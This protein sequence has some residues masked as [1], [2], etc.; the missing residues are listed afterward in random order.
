M[1]LYSRDYHRKEK[2][3][4]SESELFGQMLAVFGNQV[5]PFIEKCVIVLFPL[6]QV[7][8]AYGVSQIDVHKLKESA[9]LESSQLLACVRELMPAVVVAKVA[10][11]LDE[12]EV[13]VTTDDVRMLAKET[14]TMHLEIKEENEVVGNVESVVV[15]RTEGEGEGESSEIKK[16][17]TSVDQEAILSEE[18]KIN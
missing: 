17:E 8:K 3:D 13:I 6:D 9:R 1:A 16:N 2:L 12:K 10:D 11:V 18:F 14:T 7:Q 15:E 5:I 4:K